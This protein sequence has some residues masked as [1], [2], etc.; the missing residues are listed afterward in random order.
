[1]SK[2]KE[3]PEIGKLFE[4]SVMKW[5]SDNY[6]EKIFNN[7]KLIAIGT[8]RKDKKFDIVSSDN[9][10]VIECKCYTWTETGNVPSAKMGFVNEA[11][12]YLSFINVINPDAKTYVV[13]KKS[14]STERKQSESLASYYYRTYSH[15]LGK[16]KIIEYDD[17]NETM[18][19]I[20]TGCNFIL[21]T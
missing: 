3:N 18:K 8:P 20:E 4:M 10:I 7:D 13:M 2:N 12:F 16:T 11:V 17:I 5:L 9:L 1:M 15:L 19:D 14:I 6:P 21:E